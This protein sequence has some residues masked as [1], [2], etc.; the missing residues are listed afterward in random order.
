MGDYK[1]E[2]K[3]IPEHIVYYKDY[4]AES[5]EVFLDL[6]ADN[7]FLQDLSDRV[8]EENPQINL[9]D[10]DYNVL[11][12]MD[13]DFRNKDIH[14]RFCDAVTGFGTDCKD[15]KFTK[16]QAFTA[17]TVQHKGPYRQLEEAYAFARTWIAD[18]GYEQ[19]GPP[20]DSAID[21]CWNRQSEDDYLTEIQIPV[22][23]KGKE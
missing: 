19:A 12:Y 22:R 7:N 16:I 14:Y 2:I 21:G 1:A 17:V 11:V 23:K 6:S 5:L 10:P 13:G 18:N 4:F 8:M 15:Y 9:T 3:E 20:R